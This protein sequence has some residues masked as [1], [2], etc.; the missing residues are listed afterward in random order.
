M[1]ALIAMS[2][3]VRSAADGVIAD[4]RVSN[5]ALTH[6]RHGVGHDKTAS[7]NL[8]CRAIAVQHVYANQP[9]AEMVLILRCLSDS[10]HSKE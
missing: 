3:A 4:R 8:T 5:C 7:V 1:S 2:K 10:L 6:N 9:I